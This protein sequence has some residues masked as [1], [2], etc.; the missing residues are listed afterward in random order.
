MEN[1]PKE[2]KRKSDKKKKMEF[3]WTHIPQ[4]SRSNRENST[5][6]ESSGI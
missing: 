6:L 5:K 4:R 1:H 2:A 3:D